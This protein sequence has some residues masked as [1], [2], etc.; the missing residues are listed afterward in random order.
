MNSLQKI[1]FLSEDY[2]IHARETMVLRQLIPFG[3]KKP[4]LLQ[5]FSQVPREFFLA[6][7][8]KQ[9]AYSDS[10]IPLNFRGIMLPPHF[11][12]RLLEEACLEGQGKALVIGGG[13][14]YSAA[15][16]SHLMSLV[17]LLES[18]KVL[19]LRAEENMKTLGLDN[20]FITQGPLVEG[21]ESHAS[22]DVI[23]IEGAVDRVPVR[24]FNQLSPHGVLLTFITRGPF[25]KE[26]TCFR[27]HKNAWVPKVLFE[28]NVPALQAFSKESGFCF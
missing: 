14:G 22:F 19:A 10:L 3:V 7:H 23:L 28:G 27:R 2:F 17:F 24:I 12:G 11:L 6:E 1:E 4:E 15:L 5:A 18:H 26:A 20:V 9:T 21:L 8:Q 25:I 13:S 16:L